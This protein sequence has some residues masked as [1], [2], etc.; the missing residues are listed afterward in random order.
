MDTISTLTERNAQFAARHFSQGLS[1]MPTLRTIVLGCV[2]PRV[3]PA[4]VLGLGNGEA[5]VLRNVGGRVVPSALQAMAMLGALAPVDGSGQG[6]GWDLVLLH[7]TDCGITRLDDQ[8]AILAAYFGVNADEV[9]A[10]ELH[11]P[12]ASVEVDVTALRANPRLP[13]AF[14]LTGLVYDVATGLVETVVPTSPLRG[15]GTGL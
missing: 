5:A 1:L 8:V 10:K 11:D 7:H 14:R 2:D 3:D 15:E 6:A 12:R 4:H 9:A 13:G